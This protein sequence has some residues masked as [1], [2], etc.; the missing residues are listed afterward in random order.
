[1][2]HAGTD[3]GSVAPRLCA[4]CMDQYRASHVVGAETTP[5][6]PNDDDDDQRGAFMNSKLFRRLLR[7]LRDLRDMGPKN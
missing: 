3:I 2:R 1:M 5:R 7:D 6:W 4:L